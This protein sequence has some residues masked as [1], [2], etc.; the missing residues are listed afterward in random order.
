[1]FDRTIEDTIAEMVNGGKAVVVAGARQVGK[2][3]L[4]NEILKDKEYHE[5]V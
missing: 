2:T 4:L 3:A 1:M 5:S